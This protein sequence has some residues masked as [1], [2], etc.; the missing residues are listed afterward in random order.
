MMKKL[1]F[2]ALVLLLSPLLFVTA[3][4]NEP[5]ITAP[6]AVVMCFDTGDILY[7]RNM[8]QRWIPASM[9]KIMTAFITYQEI[10]AGNLSLDTQVRVSANA[11][12]FSNDRRVEGTFVPLD[13]GAN[14]T[15]ETLLRLVMLPSGNAAAVVLAEHI[16]GT[17]AA[18]VERMNET[19][20]ELGMYSSFNN[21]HGAFAHH[22][23]AYSIAILIREFIQQYPDILRITAMPTVRFGGTT[24]NNTNRLLS[25]HPFEGADG[26]KTGT[27]R[28]AGWGHS[29]TAIRDGRRV[30]TVLM[31][32]RNNDTRQNE[33]RI[34]LQFGFDELARRDAAAAA[35]VRVF[36]GQRVIPLNAPAV[37]ERGE[38]FLPLGD[39]LSPLGF[40]LSWNAEYR[41]VTIT[42]DDGDTSTLFVG[43]PAA[44]VRGRPITLRTPARIIDNR[45][46][47]TT[48]FIEAMT[49]TT[50]TWD[51]AT[52]VVR[53]R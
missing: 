12:R 49:G 17:E 22:S 8:E 48:Q 3:G 13:A 26:F 36:H 15:V 39:M 32:T 53:F 35:R 46:Y 18:F 43:R 19:A 34:L 40:S 37:V 11:S 27:I 51:I 31:N 33:S 21:A 42:E 50:A 5:D 14:I 52:G 7:E 10:G 6:I 29:A 41:V 24:Y 25:T 47:V 38:L 4:A 44:F 45:V 9:T 20:L 30:I 23:N 16:S 1:A 2:C 28:A